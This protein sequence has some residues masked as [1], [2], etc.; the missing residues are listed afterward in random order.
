MGCRKGLSQ[1]SVE[2]VSGVCALA[3]NVKNKLKKVRL[4][5]GPL[6]SSYL[7]ITAVVLAGPGAICSGRV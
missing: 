1:P 4:V 7:L 5:P 3:L 6:F 2:F